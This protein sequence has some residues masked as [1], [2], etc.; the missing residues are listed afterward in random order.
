M[1]E[2]V[3]KISDAASRL[4]GIQTS[5]GGSK[6]FQSNKKG[7]I[8]ELK[9][10]LNSRS[11]TKRKEAAKRVIASM[12]IGKDVSSLFPDV[13]KCIVTQDL[14]LKKL[15]YLY[16]MN[17]AHCNAEMVILAVNTFNRDAQDPNPIIR[18]LAIR[19]MGSLKTDRILD[20]LCDPLK[21]ALHD[22]SAY[23][24][25]T[26]AL[27]VPKLWDLSRSIVEEFEFVSDLNELLKDTSPAVVTNAICALRE[28]ERKSGGEIKLLIDSNTLFQLLS[29]LN[30]CTE[31][32]QVS[33]LDV[34]SGYK[35]VS[36]EESL[37]IL[38]HVCPRLNHANSA[39]VMSSVRVMLQNASLVDDEHREF[40]LRRTV[41]PLLSLLSSNYS[42]EIQFCTLRNIR[43]IVEQFS[44]LFIDGYANFFCKFADSIYIRREKMEILF[45]LC[46]SSNYSKIMHE[47]AEYCNESNF[48][49]NLLAIRYVAGIARKIPE[50]LEESSLLLEELF[51]ASTSLLVKGHCLIGL[52]QCMRSHPGWDSRDVCLKIFSSSDLEGML[53]F[54]DAEISLSFLWMYHR[55]ISWGLPLQIDEFI[56]GLMDDFFTYSVDVQI[57]LLE[58]V[59]YLRVRRRE[60]QEK[61][62]ALFMLQEIFA[63]DLCSL[64]VKQ[65]CKFWI[66]L[67][68]NFSS[69]DVSFVFTNNS[70]QLSEKT[71]KK[72]GKYLNELSNLSSVAYCDLIETGDGGST[73]RESADGLKIKPVASSQE[74]L[75]HD[76][77]DLDLT[78]NSPSQ[79]NG[80][81]ERKMQ[82]LIDFLS[83]DFDPSQPTECVSLS[84]IDDSTLTL[85]CLISRKD[86]QISICF[87]SSGEVPMRGK[88]SLLPNALSLST[89]HPEEVDLF[90][91]GG[92]GAEKSLELSY[93]TG[94][95]DNNLEMKFSSIPFTLAVTPVVVDSKEEQN[96]ISSTQQDDIINHFQGSIDIPVEMILEPLDSVDGILFPFQRN[97]DP[98]P[99]A[100]QLIHSGLFGEDVNNIGQLC[101]WIPWLSLHLLVQYEYNEPEA[102]PQSPVATNATVMCEDSQLLDLVCNYFTS[103]LAK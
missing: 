47:F 83:E 48:E 12:T 4:M 99:T 50:A 72:I 17:Y 43:C 16:L 5:P 24:R 20:Y 94:F 90:F 14:E 69:Q 30:D 3:K 28:L 40:Y 62:T 80:I 84:L 100:S 11:A 45:L 44:W 70:E 85:N 64:T 34:L 74:P 57:L 41:S 55:C 51:V 95:L 75:L 65:T 60:A 25:K 8:F 103:L 33:I 54:T 76:L 68:K 49:T 82:N 15:A 26:A 63:N 7:E 27:C 81:K 61:L 36:E 35:A 101:S 59:V 31:W 42:K 73:K 91:G 102:V 13:L 67:L 92:G 52:V 97:I 77:L 19:T 78:I 88:L 1:S 21:L 2:V 18:A 23:V 93:R 29:A 37:H 39:V 66:F 71:G 32:G 86:S 79:P 22:S 87:I 98:F 38:I 89:A 56:L 9:S 53:T 58:T 46:N 6:Y 10:E 96:A